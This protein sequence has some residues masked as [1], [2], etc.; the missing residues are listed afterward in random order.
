MF[1]LLCRAFWSFSTH[2]TTAADS[3]LNSLDPKTQKLLQNGSQGA[4]GSM[5]SLKDCCPT[6][7][8]QGAGAGNAFNYDFMD[9]QNSKA[10]PVANT[11]CKLVLL[12]N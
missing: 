3:L 9:S 1:P 8:I 7:I 5:K 10:K 4:F 6:P 11:K 2:Y 12:N